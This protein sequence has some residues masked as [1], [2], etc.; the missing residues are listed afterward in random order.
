VN[1][2]KARIEAL[3]LALV[4]VYELGDTPGHEFHGNQWVVMGN[5]AAKKEL[6][7]G[8]SERIHAIGPTHTALHVSS[9]IAAKM[10]LD[11]N[12][13]ATSYTN[14]M[15]AEH[16]VILGHEPKIG[17]VVNGITRVGA[18]SYTHG[19]ARN[20]AASA[21]PWMEFGD[22]PG[23]EFHGNQ[24]TYEVQYSE[25][26][27]AM[28]K[29]QYKTAYVKVQADNEPD[30]NLQAAQ[31]SAV[32]GGIPTSTKLISTR[33]QAQLASHGNDPTIKKGDVIVDA[34]KLG[35]AQDDFSY[36]HGATVTNAYEALGAGKLD[37]VNQYGHPGTAVLKSGVVTVERP[38]RG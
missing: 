31:M 6:A 30:A 15:D 23:H 26:H 38:A 27:E 19:T 18:P 2:L 14:S 12:P 13:G 17:D 20:L 34:S 37:Y 24:Y 28:Q 22:V 35:R 36:L 5:A 7:N 8:G 4:A 11:R 16:H 29:G 21:A 1:D 33:M 9:P 3:E 10:M 25:D 32:R